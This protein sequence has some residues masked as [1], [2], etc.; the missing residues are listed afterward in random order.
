MLMKNKYEQYRID[1]YKVCS[2]KTLK[3]RPYTTLCPVTLYCIY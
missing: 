3:G 2:H 1:S